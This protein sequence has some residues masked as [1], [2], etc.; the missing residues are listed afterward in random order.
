M[1]ILKDSTNYQLIEGTLQASGLFAII[2]KCDD[3]QTYWNCGYEGIEW[4]DR[5]LNLY[6]HYFEIECKKEIY[7]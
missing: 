7:Y 1:N 3:K 2:R 6:D 4:K 5:L